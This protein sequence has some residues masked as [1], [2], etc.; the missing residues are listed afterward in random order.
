MAARHQ[1]ISGTERSPDY[2]FCRHRGPHRH[3]PVG[4]CILAFRCESLRQQPASGKLE[5]VGITA[6]FYN[7]TVSNGNPLGYRVFGIDRQ[8]MAMNQDEICARLLSDENWS[9]Q[10]HRQQN[11]Q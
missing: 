1:A 8:N 4:A 10:Q 5:H 9:E 7:D 3:A 6:D 2:P 11:F